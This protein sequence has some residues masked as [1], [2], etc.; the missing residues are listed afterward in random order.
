MP[1]VRVYEPSGNGYRDITTNDRS[2][3]VRETRYDDGG[4]IQEH[5]ERDPETDAEETTTYEG[6][7]KVRKVKR[8][9]NGEVRHI[10]TY[11]DNG[12]VASTEVAS[13]DTG[14]S[15]VAEFE[16]AKEGR[17]I[18]VQFGSGG[19]DEVLQ[20]DY[21]HRSGA[22]S[23]VTVLRPGADGME[24]VSSVEFDEHG[25][26]V[27]SSGDELEDLLA[28]IKRHLKKEYGSAN[29]HVRRE[30]SGDRVWVRHN[31]DG[32]FDVEVTNPE[33]LVMREYYA[34]G[35]CYSGDECPFRQ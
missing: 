23:N 14:L 20:F 24:I 26:V 15:E 31:E 7:K 10:E 35:R 16:W 6:G 1:K 21:N 33:G 22:L 3:V 4:Q 5:V 19:V 28:D 2:Q 8:D 34:S 32:S 30:A 27:H 9:A 29:S 12:R 18:E 11:D 17:L 25:E 13:A